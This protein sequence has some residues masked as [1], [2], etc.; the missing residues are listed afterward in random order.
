[1]KFRFSVFGNSMIRTILVYLLVNLVM[2]VN[3]IRFK[4]ATLGF[5][6]SVIYTYMSSVLCG[7]IFFKEEGSWRKIMFGFSVFITLLS[8][9]GSVA[10]VFYQLSTRAVVL[11]L[12]SISVGLIVLNL[13]QY[14]FKAIFKDARIFSDGKSGDEERRKRLALFKVEYVSEFAYVILAVVSFLFLVTSR[15]EEVVVIWDVIHPA[16]LPSYL[17]ATFVLLVVLFSKA[18]RRTKI[19]FVIIHSLIIHSVLFLVFNPG[20]GGDPW[21]ELGRIRDIYI[22]GKNVPNIVDYLLSGESYSPSFLIY[23]AFRKRVYESLV[24]ILANMFS[25]DIYWVHFW[26][27]PVLCSIITPFLVY[28]IVK[29]LGGDEICSALGAFLTLSTPLLIFY[30]AA[31]APQGLSIVFF[32]L[33]LYFSL[34]Y[35]FLN[36]VGISLL[37]FV[38]VLLFS[39]FATHFLVGILSFAIFLLAF[40]FKRYKT[41]A[42]ESVI[43][44]KG[45]LVFTIL[46]SSALLPIALFGLYGVYPQEGSMHVR[47]DVGKLLSTDILPMLFGEYV[48]FSFEQLLASVTIPLLGILGLLYVIIYAPTKRYQHSLSSFVLLILA[49]LFVD[50]TVLKHAMVNVPFSTERIWIFRDLL[51]VPF[52]AIMI[53]FLYKVT[54][55]KARVVSEQ[56]RRSDLIKFSVVTLVF[57]LAASG[58]VV[59]ATERAFIISPVLLNTTPY[60]VEAIEYIDRTTPGRYIVISDPI[61]STAAYGILGFQSR[62]TYFRESSLFYLLFTH[63][64]AKT[65]TDMMGPGGVSSAYFVV[66]NRYRD[67]ADAVARAKKV[68]ETYAIFGDGKLYVFRPSTEQSYAVPVIVDAGNFSR[69]DYPIEF[70]MNITEALSHLAGH[71]DPNSIRVTDPKGEELPSQFDDFQAWFDDCSSLDNWSYERALGAES[72]GD[73]VAFS[74]GMTKNSPENV[75]K[76]IYTRFGSDGGGLEIDTRKFRYIEMKLRGSDADVASI[77]LV[78]GYSVGSAS[79]TFQRYIS[80]STEWSIWRYDLFALNGTLHSLWMD[81]FDGQ[82]SDWEGEF[83]LYIDWIR[84]VG[85]TGTVRFLHSGM[86]HTEVQY[87]VTLNLL[88]NTESGTRDGLPRE[89]Y[90]NPILHT[91]DTSN[92]NLTWNWDNRTLCFVID[93]EASEWN[94]TPGKSFSYTVR[95]DDV[96]VLTSD[97]DNRG[98]LGVVQTSGSVDISDVNFSNAR[99]ISSGPV[100][101]EVSYATNGYG[102]L[103]V[104]FYAGEHPRIL[105]FMEEE[106]PVIQSDGGRYS[107]LISTDSLDD[108]V[109]Y[110]KENGEVASEDLSGY[111]QA[112]SVGQYESHGYL[113]V[114]SCLSNIMG[115]Y[116]ADY[117]KF[118]FPTLD[119]MSSED[120]E[121]NDAYVMFVISENQSTEEMKSITFELKNPPTVVTSMPVD[122]KVKTVGLLDE[123]LS[124]V[125]VEVRELNMKADTDTEGWAYFVVPQGQWTIVASKDGIISEKTIEASANYVTLQRLSIAKIEGLIINLWQ[126]ALFIAIIMLGCFL[127]L[128]LLHRKVLGFTRP[129]KRLRI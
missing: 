82:L 59:L 102:E 25:V 34:R 31:N 2:L 62:A 115:D 86:A 36:K 53:V 129:I 19:F 121:L 112:Q 83:R 81:I 126:F 84:F 1:M 100:M 63:P 45:W 92:H 125:T 50:Y 118:G 22:F 58:F 44:A 28:E 80:L 26:M 109:Y 29:I 57:C 93:K 120:V 66:S 41:M 32:C 51:L 103:H 79:K 3:I 60:E 124:D 16:F 14:G 108:K 89:L 15:S 107:W 122:L 56:V 13:K 104:R 78:L 99:L 110:V 42:N 69:V 106:N 5:I 64:S 88:E 91:E 55:T 71:L 127:S 128:F 95:I 98:G 116:G 6:I 119:F 10:L 11:L 85:D 117:N 111:W 54:Y 27:S 68:F 24:V 101:A 73:A 37:V 46:I 113:I 20:L 87:E 52:A 7:N 77:R 97:S 30:G 17:V 75:G 76:L 48:N 70:E 33:T 38:L 43:M 39:S 61:I 114:S 67:F 49:V 96:N 23:F 35:L 72:D 40:A 18:S 105:F 4:S 47:F 90:S 8:A 123:P 21:H 12:L 74:L 65:L 94:G 9:G